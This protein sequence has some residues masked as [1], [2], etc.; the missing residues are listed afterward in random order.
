[1]HD[2]LFA[3]QRALTPW[4]A[5]AQAL[6]LDVV[7]FEQCL[8]DGKYAKAIRRDMAEARKSGASGTP[9]FVLARTD[10]KDAT[11]VTGITFL[12]GAQPFEAFK[13]AID[14][15]LVGK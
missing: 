1:M 12:V 10:P 3:N 5:H 7:Q 2:R 8:N 13:R 6:A 14:Q 4:Q 11:K 15:A 9:S